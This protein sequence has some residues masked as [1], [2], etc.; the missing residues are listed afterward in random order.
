[1]LGELSALAAALTIAF[2]AIIA[3]SLA[4]FIDARPLQ[5]MRAWFGGIFIFIIIPIFGKTGQIAEIPPRLLAFIA[6]SALFGVAIGDTF[7]MRTLSMVQVSRSFPT[8]RGT[9]IISTMIVASLLFDEKISLTTGAGALMI[10]GGVY[11][12]SFARPARK[13]GGPPATAAAPAAAVNVAPAA[14]AVTPVTGAAQ[15]QPAPALT[16]PAATPIKKWLFTA[17]AAGLCWTVSL[18]F[19]KVVLLEVDALVTQAFRLPVAAAMLTVLSI[20]SG[21]AKQL[22]IFQYKRKTLVLLILAGILSYGTGVIFELYAVSFAGMAKATILTSWAPLFILFLSALLL[23]EKITLRVLLGT[24]LCSGGT[25]V[26]M[27][28]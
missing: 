24:F 19:M 4:V 15:G 23:K 16:P 12:A 2:S 13:K 14:A 3:R 18:S 26:L 9:Q 20:G 17:M 7:Y 5:T 11:L 10:M 27:V 25:V 22:R 6:G 21:K 28:L 1:M 8:V